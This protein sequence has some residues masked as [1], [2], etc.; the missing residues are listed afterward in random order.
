V[1]EHRFQV[2][3]DDLRG[4]GGRQR[5]LGDDLLSACGA[6]DA[7]GQAAAAA[8]GCEGGVAGAVIA[9]SSA[10][11]NSLA[12]LG[13]ATAALAANVDAAAAAYE[14]TDRDAMPEKRQHG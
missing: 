12:N 8:A 13:G 4:A 6:L 10:W 5:A 2:N 11:A 1:G 9:F 14:G 3:T 7:A